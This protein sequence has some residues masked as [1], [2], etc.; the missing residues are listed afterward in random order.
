MSTLKRSFAIAFCAAVV[1]LAGCASTPGH[2]NYFDDAM[3]TARV[4]KAI[5]N[6]PALK[7]NEI[8]VTTE[9]AVVSLS[10]AV[11]SRNDRTKAAEVARHVE[12]VKLVKNELKVDPKVQ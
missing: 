2:N 11:K 5:Y 12:G 9:N 3:V 10:G 8:S 1:G 4:K 7:V 6:E